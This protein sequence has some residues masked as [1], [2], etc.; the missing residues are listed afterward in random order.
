M[1]ELSCSV[2]STGVN[3]VGNRAAIWVRTYGIITHCI[4]TSTMDMDRFEETRYEILLDN[5]MFIL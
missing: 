5:K 3:R 4:C 2:G 1:R